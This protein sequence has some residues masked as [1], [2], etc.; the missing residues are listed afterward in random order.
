MPVAALEAAFA[1]EDT[2]GWHRT[3]YLVALVAGFVLAAEPR[4]RTALARVARPA[5]W[6]GLGGFVVLAGA[7]LAFDPEEL[8]SGYAAVDVAWRA[9]KGV[10]GW[11]LLLGVVGLIGRLRAPAM[12]RA[13][14][15]A[16]LPVYVLHQAVL[17]LLAWRIV[18]WDAPA[19]VQLVALIA[20]TA[21]ATL[22]L[23]RFSCASPAP[24]C[25]SV[26]GRGRPRAH[27]RARRRLRRRPP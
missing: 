11:L 17:V 19:G 1:S 9:L 15:D 10:V 2:G 20:A 22:A 27:A 7:G 25:C 24:P 16:V 3:V 26:S 14:N 13:V 18:Q 5:G 23:T 21:A 4:A 12:P 6:A 8:M